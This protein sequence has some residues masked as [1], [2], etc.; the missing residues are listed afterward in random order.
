MKPLSTLHKIHHRRRIHYVDESI[1][2]FLL[3][4]LVVLETG[5]A[6]GLAWMMF[7]RLSQIIEDKL[8]RVHMVDSWSI[9]GQMMHEAIFLLVIFGVA[10]LIALLVV[11]IIWRH[12]IYSILNSFKLLMDKTSKLDFTADPEIADRHQVLD[13]AETQREQ[14]RNRLAKIREQLSCLETAMLAANDTQG[15]QDVM[16]ALDELLPR[17]GVSIAKHGNPDY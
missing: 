6:G 13:L 4:G 7:W 15:V 5:L 12:H 9:L 1:Q 16:K 10:N 3:T 17:P 8:Y 14:E 11:D 2:K